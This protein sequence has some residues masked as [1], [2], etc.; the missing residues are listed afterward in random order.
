MSEG[1]YISIC[2]RKSDTAHRG[3]VFRHNN[4]ASRARLATTK[5]SRGGGI[6]L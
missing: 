1:M 2:E 6:T 3:L 5:L 4:R